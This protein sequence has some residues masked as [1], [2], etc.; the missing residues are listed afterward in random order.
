M[1]I[2]QIK[3]LANRTPFRPFVIVLESGQQIP[4]N[5]DTELLFPTKRPRTVYLFADDGAGW[6]FEMQAVSALNENGKA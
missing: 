4:V 3:E 5:S 2:E 1:D 6:I